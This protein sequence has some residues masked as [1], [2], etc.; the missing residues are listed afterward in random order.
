MTRDDGPGAGVAPD[1]DATPDGAGGGVAP[2]DE[3]AG[4]AP[5]NP[6]FV[7]A[8]LA[9]VVAFATVAPGSWV[10]AVAAAGGALALAAG[11]LRGGRAV[12][13]AGSVG[14]AAA[15]ILAGLEGAAPLATGLGALATVVAWDAAT[16][17][18]TVAAQVGTAAEE[19]VVLAHVRDAT[20]VGGAGVGVATVAFLAGTGAS[21]LVAGA[22]AVAAIALVL[23]LALD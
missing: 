13:R 5:S 15:V 16:H 21:P 17:A 1:G 22:A 2:P 14:L 18:L 20:L 9:S 4:L 8:A 11:S 3:S 23:A 10:A 6:G 19:G 12:V 7:A